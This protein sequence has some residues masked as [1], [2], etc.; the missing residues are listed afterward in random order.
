M[1]DLIDWKR[2]VGRKDGNAYHAFL[3]LHLFPLFFKIPRLLDGL[4]VVFCAF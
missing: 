3:R 2:S 4:S 1:S